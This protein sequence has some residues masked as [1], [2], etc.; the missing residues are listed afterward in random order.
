[1][2]HLAAEYARAVGLAVEIRPLNAEV[3]P[4]VYAT[5]RAAG[6][7]RPGALVRPPP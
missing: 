5:N 7:T 2:A 4:L 1:M 6:D 3:G